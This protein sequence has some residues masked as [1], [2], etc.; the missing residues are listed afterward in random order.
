MA[1]LDSLEFSPGLEE[2]VVA[3]VVVGVTEEV[4]TEL[5]CVSLDFLVTLMIFLI[6]AGLLLAV[7]MAVASL[8]GVFVDNTSG[9]DSSMVDMAGPLLVVFLVCS[10]SMLSFEDG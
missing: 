2:G 10:L 4:L 1:G 6:V 7:A 9:G 3:L 8:V 5:G